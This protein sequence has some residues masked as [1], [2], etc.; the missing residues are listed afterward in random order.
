MST[1]KDDKTKKPKGPLV[2]IKP[3]PKKTKHGSPDIF[4]QQ[5]ITYIIFGDRNVVQM[6]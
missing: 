1:I 3:S 6:F 5:S 4:S 2:I